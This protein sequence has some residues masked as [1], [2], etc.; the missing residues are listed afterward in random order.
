MKRLGE[1][2]GTPNLDFSEKLKIVAWNDFS[3]KK[4]GTE[5]CTVCHTW[6]PLWFERLHNPTSCQ[7]KKKGQNSRE[8]RQ[9][10]SLPTSQGTPG[11]A[12]KDRWG[13]TGQAQPAWQR[14]SE[15]ERGSC[16]GGLRLWHLRVHQPECNPQVGPGTRRSGNFGRL[17]KKQPT[18]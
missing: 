7:A 16:C 5:Q 4:S 17:K 15:G 14:S 2:N 6:H 8:T 12:S 10:I 9:N 18:R 1:K 13:P 11:D 3:K